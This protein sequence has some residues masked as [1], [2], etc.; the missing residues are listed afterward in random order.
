M[1]S[2]ELTSAPGYIASWIDFLDSKG[3]MAHRKFDLRYEFIEKV[4]LHVSP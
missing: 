2:A 1:G 3:T 4:K